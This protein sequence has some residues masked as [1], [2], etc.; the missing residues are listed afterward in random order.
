VGYILFWTLFLVTF[1]GLGFQYLW[2][3]AVWWANN[4]LNLFAFTTLAFMQT[5]AISFLD[6][7]KNAPVLHRV[8]MAM[9]GLSLIGV[10]ASLLIPYRIGIR[11]VSLH[12]DTFNG[13]TH[14]ASWIQTGTLFSSCLDL[15]A[16]RAARS[17][18]SQLCH[19]SG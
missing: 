13:H 5:F 10:I 1:N 11:L 4:C 2:P 19:T 6:S 8:L 3:D 17:D 14:P 18:P 16:S 15:N 9:V 12:R 7:R